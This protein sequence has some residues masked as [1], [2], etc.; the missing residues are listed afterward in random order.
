MKI[1]Q[2]FTHYPTNQR[3]QVKG[4]VGIDGLFRAL[5]ADGTVRRVKYRDTSIASQKAP[6]ERYRFRRAILTEAEIERRKVE[7]KRMKE[8]Q[9]QG[10]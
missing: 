8:M 6:A 7:A 1:G 5:L 3:G 2:V 10:K 9:L 4:H